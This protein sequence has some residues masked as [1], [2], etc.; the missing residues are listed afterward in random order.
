MEAQSHECLP[1][2]SLVNCAK[3]RDTIARAIVADNIVDQGDE[4]VLH[5]LAAAIRQVGTERVQDAEVLVRR[6][7]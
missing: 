1:I 4:Q 7:E 2:S 3:I 6:V 5:V